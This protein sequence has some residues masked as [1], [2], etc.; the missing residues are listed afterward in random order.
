[1]PLAHPI[2]R[3]ASQLSCDAIANAREFGW[4][5]TSRRRHPHCRAASSIRNHTAFGRYH[6]DPHGSAL[7]H[8]G[9]FYLGTQD[10]SS[11]L[12]YWRRSSARAIHTVAAGMSPL[13]SAISAANSAR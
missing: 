13:R 11:L 6:Q 5:V 8:L 1:M 12:K 2:F 10:V 4:P 7:I 9:C 3:I